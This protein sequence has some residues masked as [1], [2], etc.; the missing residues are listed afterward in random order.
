ML[1]TV[2]LLQ[3]Y[4]FLTQ[5]FKNILKEIYILNCKPLEMGGNTICIFIHM[6]QKLKK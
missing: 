6:P 1:V 2:S 3:N 4:L 5:G